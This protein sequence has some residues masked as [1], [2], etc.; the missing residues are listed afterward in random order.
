MSAKP[1][2]RDKVAGMGQVPQHGAPFAA[3]KRRKPS[4]RVHGYAQVQLAESSV[5]DGFK[6]DLDE[7]VKA[8]HCTVSVPFSVPRSGQVLLFHRAM[9]AQMLLIVLRI[10]R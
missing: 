7:S 9:T 2:Q 5:V 10:R 1:R 3:T 8:G 6:G 4:E